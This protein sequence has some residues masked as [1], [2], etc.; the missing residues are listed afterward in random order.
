PGDDRRPLTALG[1]LTVGGHFMNNAQDVL[2]DRIDVTMRGLQGLTVACARC[3]DHKFDPI[4]Q[5]DYY[6]LYGVFASSVEPAVP[7]LFAEP[8]QTAEYAAFEK[9]LA[10][11]EGKLADFLDGKRRDLSV[12]ARERVSE[13]LLA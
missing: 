11:R 5:K 2:D 4:P 10:V 8:P 1:F 12:S 7:P 13:Y 6:S 9:E 3:H